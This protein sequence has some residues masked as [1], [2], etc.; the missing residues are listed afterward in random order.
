MIIYRINGTWGENENKSEINVRVLRS[1]DIRH[2]FIKIED[3]A[4]R[5]MT[6]N[7]YE[8]YK[9]HLGDILVIKSSGSQDLVGKS[10]IYSGISET[11]FV[12]SSNFIMCLRPNKTLVYPEYLDLFLKSPQALSWRF[13]RQSTTSGL[14]NLNTGEYLAVDV[15]LPSIEIQ[16]QVTIFYKAILNGNFVNFNLINQELISTQRKICDLHSEIEGNLDI[17]KKLFPELRQA[18][19]QEAVSGKLSSPRP[20]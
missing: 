12:V 3:A 14:R 7:E 1:Q 4:V 8:K 6:K 10:Q 17:R 19:L 11:E 16:K 18:I 20:K 15:P 5:S 9:L 2:N 13:D